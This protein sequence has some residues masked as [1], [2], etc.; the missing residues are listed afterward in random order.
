MNTYYKGRRAE[1]EY[2]NLLE[3]RGYQVILAPKGT[4]YQKKK[5]F[6]EH[7]D[8]IAIKPDA[9]TLFFQ[10]KSNGTH[11]YLKKLSQF[12]QQYPNLAILLAIRYSKVSQPKRWREIALN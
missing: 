2:K 4:Q 3:S 10:V 6:F 9:E 7:F 8:G 11:G 12:K 1:L 5:D